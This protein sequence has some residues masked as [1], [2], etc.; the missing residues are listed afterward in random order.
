MH[1]KVT[2]MPAISNNDTKCQNRTLTKVAIE[3][4]CCRHLFSLECFQ[5]VL[6]QGGRATANMHEKQ[7]SVYHVISIAEDGNPLMESEHE[8]IF[9]HTACHYWNLR[10][11]ELPLGNDR[12][13]AN[14]T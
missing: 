9:L 2:G 12:G 1:V 6:G 14:R 4:E 10:I 11:I 3:E 8:V 5:D 13:G 7:L